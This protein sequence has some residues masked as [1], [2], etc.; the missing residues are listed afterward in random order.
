MSEQGIPTAEYGIFDDYEA[1]RRFLRAF[2]RPA[3]VKA[4]GLAAGKGVIVCDTVEEAGAA[5]HQI[6]VERA[7]GDAGS[8]VVIEERLS[9]RE[10]SVLAFCDGK[11]IVPMPVSRDHKRVYDHDQGPN[12]GG[13]GAFTPT[14]DVSQAQIDEVCRTVLQPAVK[15]MAARGTPYRGVLYAGIMLAA[16]GIKVLEFNCRFGDPETQVIL[17]LL[18]A[19]LFDVCR[20]CAEGRL[21]QIDVSWLPQACATV[22]LAAPGYPAAYPKGLPI[23]GLEACAALDNVIVF[24]AGTALH[25]GQLVTSG[26]RV[27]AVTAIGADLPQALSRAYAGVDLIHFEK[28]HFRRDIGKQY[29]GGSI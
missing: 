2:G 20:A 7:F 22:V 14:P 13:M 23:S 25:D 17:P 6:M 11:T 16:D 28:K 1:A 19:D 18:A 5:L 10:I 4:D 12:T 29:A 27:L 3:V 21:D 26:G 15:G 8:R 24:H 9:G